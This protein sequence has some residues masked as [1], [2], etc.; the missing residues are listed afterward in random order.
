[1]SERE[2]KDGN[3]FVIFVI[4]LKSAHSM[5]SSFFATLNLPTVGR[6]LDRTTNYGDIN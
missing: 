4:I 6:H 1:M 5:T 3:I 2:G